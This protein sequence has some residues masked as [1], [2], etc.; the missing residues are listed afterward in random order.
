MSG[1]PRRLATRRW[2]SST[3]AHGDGARDLHPVSVLH[4][5]TI[6]DLLCSLPLLPSLLAEKYRA[7]FPS[8]SANVDAMPSA[9]FHFRI[10]TVRALLSCCAHLDPDHRRRGREAA[11]HAGAGLPQADVRDA[12]RGVT[13]AAPSTSRTRR[14]RLRAARHGRRWTATPQA[15]RR[16]GPAWHLVEWLHARQQQLGGRRRRRRS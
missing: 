5:G 11:S 3:R 10:S 14:P 4:P 7:A 2:N 13:M 16:G 1:S 12:A 6:D 9:T 8:S 15:C